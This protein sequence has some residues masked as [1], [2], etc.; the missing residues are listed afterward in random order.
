MPKISLNLRKEPTDVAPTSNTTFNAPGNFLPRYGKTEF[1]VGGKG[2]P[3]NATTGGNYAGTNPTTGGNYA[4]TNAPT[5]GNYAYTN[6]PTPGNISGYSEGG[7]IVG[8]YYTDYGSVFP[9][10]TSSGNQMTVWS[11]NTVNVSGYFNAY[12]DPRYDTPIYYYVVSYANVWQQYSYNNQIVKAVPSPYALN[13]TNSTN[14]TTLSYTPG[15][16]LYNPAT[17]GNA[18]YNPIYPGYAYYNP[19]V[20]GNA[21]Y[22]P[23]VP[24][25]AGANYSLGGV[26]FP[27]AAA[28]T[29]AS[30]VSP[31]ISTLRYN[32]PSGIVISTPAG[33]YVNIT[34]KATNT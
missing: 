24:G 1:L 2:A 30:V 17:P 9:G 13:P 20:P 15:G 29:E 7:F 4:G 3:G 8:S 31:T 23:T 21:Y 33:G 32:G 11:T 28:D 26:Y 6:S 19:T 27:G 34:S 5:G 16:P 10:Y 25:T 18:V 22:N 14:F 12:G